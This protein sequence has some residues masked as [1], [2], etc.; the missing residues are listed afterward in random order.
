MPKSL[1]WRGARRAGCAI[2]HSCLRFGALALNIENKK[3]FVKGGFIFILNS[4][5]GIGGFFSTITLLRGN[6]GELPLPAYYG[7]VRERLFLLCWPVNGSPLWWLEQ[8][9]DTPLIK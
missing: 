9:A 4:M 3:G 8:T 5:L 6:H 7:C 1:V 2:E